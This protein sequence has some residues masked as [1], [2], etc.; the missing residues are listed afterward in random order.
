[1]STLSNPLTCLRISHCL[2]LT[3]G[4][5]VSVASMSRD[6][7]FLVRRRP[8]F[9][10][11]SFS[12]SLTTNTNLISQLEVIA[13]NYS[14]S[15][16]PAKPN[17]GAAATLSSLHRRSS[18]PVGCSFNTSRLARFFRARGPTCEI[19]GPHA[20]HLLSFLALYAHLLLRVKA[21]LICF[22]QFEIKAWVGGF[23]HLQLVWEMVCSSCNSVFSLHKTTQV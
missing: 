18:Q 10:P 1:M 22:T 15:R 6:V 4:A 3:R 2:L 5:S 8:I 23:T 16:G 19:C 14:H 13:P 9:I 12:P 17:C 20:L 11:S 7:A 21:A